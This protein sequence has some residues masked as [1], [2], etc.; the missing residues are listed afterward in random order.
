MLPSAWTPGSVPNSA[1]A[2]VCCEAPTLSGPA[3]R[4]FIPA[5]VP[6]GQGLWEGGFRV[7]LSPEKGNQP[8]PV[9]GCRWFSW[10]YCR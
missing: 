1:V 5:I 6:R 9:T 3:F 8:T 4:G 7:E 2:S 10:L